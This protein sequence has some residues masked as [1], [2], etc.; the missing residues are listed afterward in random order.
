MIHLLQHFG[1]R[2]APF[3]P[4][5]P[6][7]ESADLRRVRESVTFA[8]EG[9]GALAICGGVG[10]GKTTAVHE[11]L[12]DLA[13]LGRHRVV[14]VIAPDRKYMLASTVEAAFLLEL[15]ERTPSHN[16]ERRAHQVRAALGDVGRR[17]QIVLVIDEAHALNIT[18]LRALKRLRE[19]RYA[20]R[21][22]LFCLILIGQ[23]SLAERLDRHREI[24]LRVDAVDLRGMA[25]AEMGAYLRHCLFHAGNV[26]AIAP[27]A[28]DLLAKHQVEPLVANR[29]ASK[30]MES[31]FLAGHAR[32]EVA[33]VCQ[34]LGVKRVKESKQTVSGD[35]LADFVKSQV[36]PRHPQQR[37]AG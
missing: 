22:P 5:V 17:Q 34:V 27:E 6:L 37:A 18:T 15:S 10:F 21:C 35:E 24:G 31:A 19:M 20:G 14:E 7:F 28:I 23:T 1:L 3:G 25:P 16:A 8:A 33:D 4:H 9:C 11:V 29:L 26:D 12:N 2:R 32:V 13:A 30:A 36:T